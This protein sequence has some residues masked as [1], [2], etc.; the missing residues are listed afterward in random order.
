MNPRNARRGFRDRDLRRRKKA[1]QGQQ[2]VTP[3][4]GK[5]MN[6]RNTN[7]FV[8]CGTVLALTMLCMVLAFGGWFI[9]GRPG[10]TAANPSTPAP[11]VVEKVVVV[12][13][14]VPATAPTQAPVLTTEA[15]VVKEAPAPASTEAPVVAAV[16]CETIMVSRDG[17]V[18][19]K[20]TGESLKTES[21]FDYGDRETSTGRA[22][23]VPTVPWNEKLTAEQ[24]ELVET[25]WLDYKINACSTEAVI[26]AGG[27][28][29]N[30]TKFDGGVLFNLG[31]GEKQFRSRNGEI[32]LWYDQPH[33]D[34]D[35]GR[36]IDQIKNGNF[37]IQ[38]PLAL[39][40]ADG[41]KDVPVVADFL[42]TRPEVKIVILP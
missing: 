2:K 35:L 27:F 3:K 4:E 12:T 33:R 9:A 22:I 39:A 8:G 21:K 11:Q 30:N 20:K 18:T 32:V 36:I 37:D 13:V 16:P 25:T 7:V 42:A 28:E 1:A 17:G 6:E 15:P 14:E 41:L 38:G 26:F 23:L 31:K 10:L 19:W 29:M 40:L 34:K 24:L 5:K